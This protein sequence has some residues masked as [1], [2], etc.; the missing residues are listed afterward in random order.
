MTARSSASGAKLVPELDHLPAW[1]PP[2]VSLYLRHTATGLSLRAL[3]REYGCHASTVLRQVRRLE[4]RRDDPLVDNALARLDEVLRHK[5]AHLPKGDIDMTLPRSDFAVPPATSLAEMTVTDAHVLAQLQPLASP[6]AVL[7]VAT[8]MPK[9]VIMREDS[10]GQTQRLAVL[11]RLLAET[12]ALRDWIIC[13]KP[14]RV[15]C[16]T[17]TQ[18]GHAALRAYQATLSDESDQGAGR[19]ARFGAGRKPCQRS[20]APAR[21]RRPPVSIR[22]LSRGRRA[23]ARRFYYGPASGAGAGPY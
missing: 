20:G 13:S 10:T 8:D 21:P 5:P 18:A 16:Y 12:M 14:G 9:A 3:A 4:N 23:A 7:V 11:D 19:R 1:V 22:R 2:S 17:L 6:G 15:A